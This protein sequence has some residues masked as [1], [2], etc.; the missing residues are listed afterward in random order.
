MALGFA[1]LL[2]SDVVRADA[3]AGSVA[4]RPASA[5]PSARPALGDLEAR[6]RLLFEAIVRD[7]PAYASAIFFPRD[8]FLQVKAMQN[9]GRYFDRLEARFVQDIHT[10]H[11]TLPDLKRA[12]FAHVELVHRG[13]WVKPGE[14][15]NRLPYWASRH[16]S[17]VYR[18][19]KELRRLELRVLITWQD[20]WYVIHLSDF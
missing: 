12:A 9:P 15:G 2:V 6:A 16:S 14:E 19:G 10:L 11:R 5:T 18:V 13:G 8:A 7:D 17:L 3:D 1:G 20:R 4:P